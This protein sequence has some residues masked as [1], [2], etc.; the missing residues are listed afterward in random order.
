M[1]KKDF[2]DGG[3]PINRRAPV[4]C[5]TE[6]G[7]VR[8]AYNNWELSKAVEPGDIKKMLGIWPGRVNTDIFVLHPEYYGKMAPPEEHRTIDNADTIIIEYEGNTFSSVMYSLPE[9]GEK[10]TIIQS[11]D[12]KLEQY[13]KKAGRKYQTRFM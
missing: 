13:V 7:T 9:N 2:E 1:I 4:L 5:V 11:K 6:N 10:G 12:P 3:F 8:I